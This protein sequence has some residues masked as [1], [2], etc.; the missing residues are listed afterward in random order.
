M[1]NSKNPFFK[2]LMPVY[3]RRDHLERSITSLCRQSIKNFCL[4]VI[5]D[6]STDNSLQ[7]AVDLAESLV[8]PSFFI[9]LPKNVG[10]GAALNIGAKAFTGKSISWLTRLD[11]DD[12]YASDYLENR[13]RAIQ[14]H[15]DVDLFYGGMSVINGP[16]TVPDARDRNRRIAIS[17]TSQ[18]ATLVVKSE[19]FERLGGFDDL[20]FGEDYAFLEK[21]RLSECSIRHLDFSDY[22]YYRD[23][24]NSL[25]S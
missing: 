8:H 18:G 11:S 1:L 2:V 15:P 20:R 3:N 13:L 5:D 16:D 10:V 24:Q 9:R 19:V 25:T 6:G 12:E 22:H 7:C 23:T 14:M 21:A 4:V 17:E